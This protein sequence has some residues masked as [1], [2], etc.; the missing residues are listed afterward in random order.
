MMIFAAIALY[1][2][3]LWNRGFVVPL[4]PIGMLKAAACIVVVYYLI[5]PVS[6]II[7]LPLNFITFGFISFLVYLFAM[8]LMNVAFGF[9]IIKDWVFGEISLFG[10][11]LQETQISYLGN[12]V[13]SSVLLSS[14][15]N[16]LE[17]LL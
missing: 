8:H 17:K 13:L 12:L 16:L 15:I 9:I 3:S 4:T 5:V 6:K 2:T 14:I 1:L 10:L 11:T 7:L